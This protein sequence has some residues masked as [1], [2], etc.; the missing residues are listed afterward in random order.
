MISVFVVGWF[1]RGNIMSN[2]PVRN[3]RLFWLVHCVH[4]YEQTC[5]FLECPGGLLEEYDYVK[6]W[7]EY[8]LLANRRNKDGLTLPELQQVINEGKQQ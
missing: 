1:Q 6:A 4:G 5:S 7:E 3:M 2:H 8:Y